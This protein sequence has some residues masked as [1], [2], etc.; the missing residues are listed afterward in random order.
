MGR[1]VRTVHVPIGE[2]SASSI[3]G[4]RVRGGAYLVV[5]EPDGVVVGATFVGPDAG[6]ML[7]SA[8]IAVV[9]Q[10][11]VEQ[12]RHAVPAFPTLSELWLELVLSYLR[13]RPA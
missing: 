6:E 12:L 8:T 4:E 3:V 13:G 11:T 1:D 9:G 2:V 10:M 7:Q 5:E